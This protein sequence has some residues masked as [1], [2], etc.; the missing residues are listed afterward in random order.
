MGSGSAMAGAPFYT[1][2]AATKAYDVVLGEG[3]WYEFKPANVDVLSVIPGMVWS[4]TTQEVFNTERVKKWGYI[5]NAED[6]VSQAM[7]QLGKRPSYAP[8]FIN[9]F[10]FFV[11]RL[12]GRKATIKFIGK[13]ALFNFFGGKRP[14]IL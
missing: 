1:H 6:V 8:G 2:Y 14:D 5:M 13:N 12:L 4:S 7:A 3:L 10:G 11:L 9:R